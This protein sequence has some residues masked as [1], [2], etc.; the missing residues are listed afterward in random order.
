MHY[1]RDKVGVE[2]NWYR[3]SGP[4]SGTYP[5]LEVIYGTLYLLSMW[6][7][8]KYK[9]HVLSN[10]IVLLDSEDKS[11]FSFKITANLKVL[12]FICFRGGFQILVTLPR[13]VHI[14]NI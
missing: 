1:W 7:V 8:D 2:W 10:Y 3:I 13:L 9:E 4:L 12:C 11:Y 5:K 14:P 6:Y